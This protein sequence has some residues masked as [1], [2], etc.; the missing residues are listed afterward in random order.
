M[1]QFAIDRGNG[2]LLVKFEGSITV[3]SLIALDRELKSFIAREGIMP[4]VIDF[5]DITS[6]DVQISTL[7]H[8]GKN[9]SLMPGQ[10]RVFVATESLLFGLLRVYG[11]Y[12]DGRGER[13][14]MIV[15]SLGDAFATLSLT[16]PKFEP[17]ENGFEQAGT[18]SPAA[19]C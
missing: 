11:A 8:R 1:S 19:A 9:R 16:D 13:P 12:Q 14:P 15:R 3:E 5:T 2:V 4:T 7:V 6:V 10:Q 17:I 18:S